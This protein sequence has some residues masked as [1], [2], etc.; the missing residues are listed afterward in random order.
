[1]HRGRSEARMAQPSMLHCLA[2]RPSWHDKTRML[3]IIDDNNYVS[4]CLLAY[5]TQVHTIVC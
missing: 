3:D 5:C 1:M 4:L 2:I